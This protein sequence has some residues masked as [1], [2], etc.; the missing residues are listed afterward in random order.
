MRTERGE[1]GGGGIGEGEGG[2]GGDGDGG[3]VD[4]QSRDLLRAAQHL[5]KQYRTGA[6]GRFVL[7]NL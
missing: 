7:D 4:L 6:L 3:A 2:H 1:R 5:I